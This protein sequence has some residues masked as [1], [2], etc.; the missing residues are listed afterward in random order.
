MVLREAREAVARG[1]A[2]SPVDPV[3]AARLFRRAAA[4][5]AAAGD[6]PGAVGAWEREVAAWASCGR[7]G[8][9]VKAARAALRGLDM[10]AERDARLVL[11]S[12][13]AVAVR[14]AGLAGEAVRLLERVVAEAGEDAAGRAGGEALS[15][16]AAALANL[17]VVRIEQG[18][19]EAALALLAEAEAAVQRL[20]D[21]VR[22]GT[23]RSNQAIAYS[24][25]NRPRLARRAYAEAA[26][27]YEAGGAAAADV[28]CAVRGEAATL[29]QTG[30]FAEAIDRY[31]HAITLFERAGLPAEVYRTL[32]GEV[33]A[34]SS[35]GQEIPPA[36]LNALERRLAGMPLNTV[37]QMAR[38]LG[39]IRLNKGDF[40]GADRL[41]R[42]ARR[43]F[44][45]LGWLSDVASVD[46]NRAIAARRAGDHE[47]A[48]R[49]LTAHAVTRRGTAGGCRRRTWITIWRWFWKRSRTRPTRRPGRCCGR[50]LPD[51]AGRWQRSTAT[52][53]I[54]AAPT[55]GTRSSRRCMRA[56]SRRRSSSRC[57]SASCHLRLPWWSAR[58]CS[59]S[60][61]P[62]GRR[63]WPTLSPPQ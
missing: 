15:V 12:N 11:M 35:L 17:S 59:P 63:N 18:D 13:L 28:G 51:P 33:M 32:I 1:E 31:R 34:R 2:L 23:I 19:P 61:L 36:E 58:G 60:S 56:C 8:D 50:H 43:A 55:T 7:T 9:A 26:A 52:G 20:G 40:D 22:L 4:N 41:Y 47:K 27:L 5:S 21:R 54:L 25:L 62:T 37:G 29:A 53:M 44:Q 3:A 24:T 16:L 48:R 49:L 38:N 10:V 6:A 14:E 45:R 46:S 42:R 30:R 57:G 39:N